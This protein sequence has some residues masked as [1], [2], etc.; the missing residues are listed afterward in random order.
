[1]KVKNF[2]QIFEKSSNIKLMKIR[3]LGAQLFQA[4]C[5]TERESEGQKE[6]HEKS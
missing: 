1:M 3:V 6:I 2:Q 4:E 5:W